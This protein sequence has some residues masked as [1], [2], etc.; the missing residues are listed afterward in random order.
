MSARRVKLGDVVDDYCPRCRLVMNHGVMALDGT[1]I[2]KVQCTTCLND[3]PYRHAKLPR[4]KDPLKSAY[5]EL[6]SKIPGA[7]SLVPPPEPED[8]E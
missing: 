1:S 8:E 5:D 2:L 7:P 3:H 4:K 6:L